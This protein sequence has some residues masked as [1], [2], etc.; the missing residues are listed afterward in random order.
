MLPGSLYA[1]ALPML[2]AASRKPNQSGEVYLLL[3]CF[4]G[5]GLLI[6]IPTALAVFLFAG[7]MLCFVLGPAYMGSVTSTRILIWFLP[8]AAAGAPLIA[9]LAADGHGADTTEI[10]ATAFAVASRCICCWIP[11]GSCRWSGSLPA[12]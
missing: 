12:S 10:F 5:L 11:M 9:A 6:S 4:V 1:I 7:E 8:M 2:S 3:R